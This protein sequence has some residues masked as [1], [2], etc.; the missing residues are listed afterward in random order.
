MTFF[1][2]SPK[3]NWLEQ[4]D[5]PLFVSRRTLSPRK[6]LPRAKAVWAL[7]CGGFTELSLYGRWTIT[8]AAYAGEVERFAREVGRLAWAPAQDWMC[9]PAILAKTGLTVALHQA[10]TIESYRELREGWAELPWVP[11]LQGWRLEDYQRHVD[12]Y[13][14]AGVAL[15]QLPLV[16][17]G[18]VCRRQHSREV[19]QIIRALAPLSL[20]GF[21]VKLTGLRRAA[22]GLVSADSMAWSY[23]ARRRPA[24]P[25]CEHKNCAN[26]RRYA[27]GWREHVLAAIEANEMTPQQGV[28][29]I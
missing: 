19:E 15:E 7:D 29:P 25:E 16:G 13:A 20:H 6:R 17:L 27:V 1:L 8:A 23:H 4:L 9:E 3:A 14:A 21:G 10:R 26:C 12:Q 5:V 22:D 2:G 11:V 24:L 18:S 28:L